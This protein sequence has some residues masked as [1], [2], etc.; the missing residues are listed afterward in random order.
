MLTFE[1]IIRCSV[2]TNSPFD[3]VNKYLKTDILTLT[4]PCKNRCCFIY[5]C[6]CICMYIYV[7]VYIHTQ[8]RKHIHTHIYTHT[9]QKKVNGLHLILIPSELCCNQD[10]VV[11]ETVSVNSPEN[12][13]MNHQ[14]KPNLLSTQVQEP[15]KCLKQCLYTLIFT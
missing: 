7:C 8:P 10:K 5:I 13:K 11:F 12:T 4:E 14:Q 15:L 2:Y 1:I 9:A 6:V 3:E